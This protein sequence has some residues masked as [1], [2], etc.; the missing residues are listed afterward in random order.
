MRKI[1]VVV[2][3]HPE[4]ARV[5]PLILR[6]KQ[7]T[8]LETRVCLAVPQREVVEQEL[9]CFGIQANAFPL[10]RMI[11]KFKPDCVLVHGDAR[12][13][14]A[15]LQLDD[16]GTDSFRAHELRHAAD[17]PADVIATNYFVHSD[18]SR[19]RLLDDGVS[20][21]NVYVTDSTLL[22]A[23]L[24][25]EE[26]IRGDAALESELD[27]VF[28]FIDPDKRLLLVI[29]DESELS[30]NDSMAMQQALQALEM[31]PDVQIVHLSQH[32]SGAGGAARQYS[33]RIT[34]FETRDCLHRAYLMRRAY[35][36][37]VT[38]DQLA[39]EI[40]SMGKP[41]LFLRNEE[42]RQE[43]ADAAA[44]ASADLEAN[45]IFRE[46]R[47]FLDDEACYRAVS[48]PRNSCGDGYASQRIVETLFG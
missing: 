32:G 4:V 5:I 47:L 8:A 46:C 14:L 16:I 35:L 36:I 12:S 48:M 1:L 6:L 31:R 3:V 39:E 11:A 44:S 27:D 30:R 33:P 10:D 41:V 43:A 28:S 17:A 40:Q 19:S 22:D 37:L 18:L 29:G 42:N 34:F 26:R 9:N 13:A 15:S 2:G 38:G 45:R 21:D 23:L 7:V 24:M 25:A 20:P